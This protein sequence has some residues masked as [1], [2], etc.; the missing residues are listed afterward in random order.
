MKVPAIVVRQA[1]EMLAS[2]FR[3]TA[4]DALAEAVCHQERAA[5]AAEAARLCIEEA[6]R[7]VSSRSELRQWLETLGEANEE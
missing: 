3:R 4:D 2:P 7:I 1:R 6:E 5:A